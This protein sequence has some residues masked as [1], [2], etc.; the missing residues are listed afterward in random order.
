MDIRTMCPK[1]WLSLKGKYDFNSFKK[2][3]LSDYVLGTV[4]DVK[5]HQCRK[6]T[7][8]KKLAFKNLYK[9]M[10][11][12]ANKFIWGFLYQLLVKAK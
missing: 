11:W 2:Y 1:I 4:L 9:L 7:N 12:V 3:F 6:Q 8:R 5:T 10:Y